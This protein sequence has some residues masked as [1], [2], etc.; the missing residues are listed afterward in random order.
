MS[1]RKVKGKTK[2]VYLPV[3]V[4]T[5][6][7]ARSLV[8]FSSGKLIAAVAGTLAPNLAGVLVGAIAATDE[9]FATELLKYLWRRMLFTNTQ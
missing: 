5:V 4:S 9:D 6:L 3:T 7:S 2:D 1:F 8:T